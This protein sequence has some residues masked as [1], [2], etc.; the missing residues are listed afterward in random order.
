MKNLVRVTKRRRPGIGMRFRGSDLQ[1]AD[2]PE[3]DD[4]DQN[5][6]ENPPEAGSAVPIIAMIATEA[7]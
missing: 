3:H 5:Q 4:N 1:S 6:A 7:A 2:K